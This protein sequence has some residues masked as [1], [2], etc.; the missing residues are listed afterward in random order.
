M[1]RRGAPDVKRDRVH[2][3]LGKE[4]KARAYIMGRRMGHAS[5][6]GYLRELIL[7]GMHED[8]KMHPTA[9]LR[10]RPGT[11]VF[12]QSDGLIVPIAEAQGGERVWVLGVYGSAPK[13]LG[14]G[15]MYIADVTCGEVDGGLEGRDVLVFCD[16]TA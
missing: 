8:M 4:I 10:T 7:R 2:L 11:R 13:S 9:F 16:D 3:G 1:G 15:L 12:H 14:G 6:T 5:L